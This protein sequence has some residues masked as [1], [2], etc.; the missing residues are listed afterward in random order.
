MKTGPSSC[1]QT[2]GLS[3]PRTRPD[4]QR[5]HLTSSPRKAGLGQLVRLCWEGWEEW[6]PMSSLP[7]LAF[8]AASP[9][10]AP[11]CSSSDR[12]QPPT[13]FFCKHITSL[14]NPH[15]SS[16][17]WYSYPILQSN[18][19][20]VMVPS[21]PLGSLLRMANASVGRGLGLLLN[22]ARPVEPGKGGAL[23]SPRQLGL[24]RWE[25]GR[26]QTGFSKLRPAEHQ[27]RRGAGRPGGWEMGMTVERQA[28]QTPYLTS[29]RKLGS[30]C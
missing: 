20:S 3:P 11:S 19:N 26:W 2:A 7:L 4:S 23:G 14:F 18:L 5:I 24:W 29:R 30:T 8:K 1:Y 22:P 9:S 21:R 15:S 10:E 27:A 6:R 13:E 25:G 17:S 28:E 12:H 16:R